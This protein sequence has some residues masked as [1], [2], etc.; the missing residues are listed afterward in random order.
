[1][2]EAIRT[3]TNAEVRVRERWGQGWSKVYVEKAV[4]ELDEDLK[5]WAVDT[6]CAFYQ[7]LQPEFDKMKSK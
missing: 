6:M 5:V 4:N 3:A 7:I 1:M 2:K